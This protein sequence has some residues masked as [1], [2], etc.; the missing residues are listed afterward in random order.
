MRNIAELNILV[1]GRVKPLSG[2][3]QQT[4][5]FRD[6][7]NF[8]RLVDARQLK[9]KIHASKL[10]FI[11]IADESLRSGVGKSSQEAIANAL[12]ITLRHIDKHYNIVEVEHIE[13]TQYPWFFFSRV[14]V[15]PYRVQQDTVQPALNE[16]M[17][18]PISPR[19]KRL[20]V[21]APELYPYYGSAIPTLKEML[22]S[23]RSSQARP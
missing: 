10:D 15:C 11:S 16:S 4:E 8:V 7:W 3:M 22:I 21:N 2:L 12:E 17:P 5:E 14:K 19:H 6:G 13:L 18:L 23:S 9:K 20:P 1:R